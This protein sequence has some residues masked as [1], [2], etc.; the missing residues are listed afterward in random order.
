MKTYVLFVHTNNGWI[1]YRCFKTANKRALA[2]G[3]YRCYY[4]V[5][6]RSF[7]FKSQIMSPVVR[8]GEFYRSPDACRESRVIKQ[9]FIIRKRMLNTRSNFLVASGTVS[10]RLRGIRFFSCAHCF[11]CNRIQ[12]ARYRVCEKSV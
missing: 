2:S 3:F 1:S 6:S 11:D 4:L 5:T 9:R 10:L 8:L 12:L 7:V